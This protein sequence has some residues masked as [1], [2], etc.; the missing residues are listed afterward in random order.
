MIIRKPKV[1]W[2]LF[3]KLDL[4]VGTVER[5]ES[6]PR[7]RRPAIK[8]WLNFGP[9]VGVLKTSA[10]IT[11]H[12]QP[13][14]LLGRQLVAVVNFPPKQ[15]ANFMSECL[16]VGALEPSGAV[17]LLGVDRPVELGLQIG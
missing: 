11:D 13:E 3:N 15:I 1:S 9:E 4:R 2:D 8:L 12:Y 6:F 16:V 7:A 17:V 10:Q 14:A 5:A